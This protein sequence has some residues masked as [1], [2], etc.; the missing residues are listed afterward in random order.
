MERRRHYRVTPEFRREVTVDVKGTR[1]QWW[2]ANLVDISVGGAALVL[3]QESRTSMRRGDKVTL[4]FQSERLNAPVE[5]PSQIYY[6]RGN[7]GPHRI[8]IGFEEWEDA[9]SKLGPRLR[10]LFNQRQAFRVDVDIATPIQVSVT[11]EEGSKPVRANARDFSILGVG[12]W[13]HSRDV[14]KFRM[15]QKISIQFSLPKSRDDFQLGAVVR[16][17][18]AEGIQRAIGLEF[19]PDA[20]MGTDCRRLLRDYV[21]RR[22]LEMRRKGV[23]SSR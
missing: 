8:G 23:R 20:R 15:E 17:V 18:G 7:N 16:H 6:V 3:E 21:M 13:I 10:S 1:G 22:Q 11:L 2:P 9:R 5:V 19:I 4:R 14:E 12:L